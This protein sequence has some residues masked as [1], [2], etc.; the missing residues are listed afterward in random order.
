LDILAAEQRVVQVSVELAEARAQ[1][2]TAW[3]RLHALVSMVDEASFQTL[4]AQLKAVK[5]P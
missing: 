5:Q 1:S 4:A 3:I 2:L